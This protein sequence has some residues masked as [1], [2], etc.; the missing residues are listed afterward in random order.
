LDD[1]PRRSH[2]L[3]WPWIAMSLLQ[4]CHVTLQN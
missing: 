4:N 2:R 1:R 3:S